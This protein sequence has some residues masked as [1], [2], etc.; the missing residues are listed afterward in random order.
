MTTGRLPLLERSIAALAAPGLFVGH[1]LILPGDEHALLPDERGAFATSVVEV[2]R[3]SGAARVVARQLLTHLGHPPL[4]VPKM[5]SGMSI[6]PTG[7][8][9]SLAHDST[10]AVA[11]VALQRD[12]LSLGID[13]EP[14]EP[15]DSDLLPIV[16]TPAERAKIGDDPYDGRLLFA[17]K[18]AVY[19][20]AY[21]LDRTFLEHHDVEVDL[22]AGAATI[23]AGRIVNF[24]YCLSSHIVVLAHIPASAL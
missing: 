8:V 24:R 4:A 21:P 1:R 5:A 12:F 18:E 2:R 14:A 11:A 13:V 15:L 3:A 7:I 22:H 17:I 19:K 6:W 10:I 23:R 16:A 20:S 9:G